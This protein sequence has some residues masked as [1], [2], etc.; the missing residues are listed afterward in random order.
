MMNV[1]LHLTDQMVGLQTGSFVEIISLLTRQKRVKGVIF[2]TQIVVTRIIGSFNVEDSIM[3]K[4][5]N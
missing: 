1:E 2:S 5:N 3:T 4:S